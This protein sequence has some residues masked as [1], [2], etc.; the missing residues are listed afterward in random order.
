MNES[1]GYGVF[2]GETIGLIKAKSIKSENF[3]G[4]VEFFKDWKGKIVCTESPIYLEHY[5]VPARHDFWKNVD[6]ESVYINSM[7]D[8]PNYNHASTK[9]MVYSPHGGIN[10]KC[11]RTPDFSGFINLE[12]LT[13]H[14]LNYFDFVDL[15]P[16]V[17]LREISFGCSG[18]Y[19][20][21]GAM[22]SPKQF[23]IL[24]KI[25]NLS[26]DNVIKMINTY[27]ER[28]P[29][30]DVT[31]RLNAAKN[32]QKSL[33]NAQNLVKTKMQNLLWPNIK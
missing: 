20:K 1:V 13:I 7:L 29:D 19:P 25:A 31:E 5:D 18:Y 2:N 9:T 30:A 23:R 32:A 16:L 12:N 15:T 11:N 22:I 10:S 33:L 14:N 24:K 17:S 3:V 4:I 21:N 28:F 6:I 27:N 26:D 8:I